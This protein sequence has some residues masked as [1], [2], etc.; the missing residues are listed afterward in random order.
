MDGVAPQDQDIIAELKRKLNERTVERDELL[1]QQIAT[2]GVLKVIASSPSDMKPA[3]E[4]IATSAN[5]LIGGFSATVM[6][7]TLS[8]SGGQ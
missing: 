2:A 5:R 4:A 6:R 7:F 1:E 8:P 3:F